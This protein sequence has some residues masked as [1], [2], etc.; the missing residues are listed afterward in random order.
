M[1]SVLLTRPQ[2]DSE[3]AARRLTQLGYECVIEPL[4]TI[5]PVSTPAPA[6]DNP[7]AVMITSAHALDCLDRAVCA[8]AGLLRLPCFCVGPAS[9]AAAEAFGFASVHETAGDGGQLAQ[10][11]RQ[12][13]DAKNGDILHIAGRDIDS[14][15]RDELERSGYAVR[16]WVVYAADLA[17]ALSPATVGL[18]REQKLDAA[19]LFSTRTAATLKT[20]VLRHGLEACCAGVIALGI[21]EAVLTALDGLSWRRLDAAPSPTEDAVFQ[22]LQTLLPPVKK[23]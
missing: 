22:R 8:S 13:L 1:P 5:R 7:Q 18:W 19:L 16:I 12:T 14:K 4:L 17:E 3:Q 23:P 6:L 9:G 21:S 15:G 10:K 2:K 11:I 20:L